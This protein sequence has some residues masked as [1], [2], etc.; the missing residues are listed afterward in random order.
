MF[1]T[2]MHIY[3]VALHN[4]VWEEQVEIKLIFF[5][6]READAKSRGKGMRFFSSVPDQPLEQQGT[7]IA[8][9]PVTGFLL[10]P[11]PSTDTLSASG[12]LLRPPWL[13]HQC[14]SPPSGG[15]TS[16]FHSAGA[17]LVESTEFAFYILYATSL[18]LLSAGKMSHSLR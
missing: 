1:Q 18:C 8:L 5:K 2:D 16:P 9:P 11:G 15:Y 7:G 17:L 12:A 3:P 10:P 13:S 14:D 6:K 4:L